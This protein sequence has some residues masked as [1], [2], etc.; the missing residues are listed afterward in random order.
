MK[1]IILTLLLLFSLVLA[2]SQEDS[3]LKGNLT[4]TKIIKE[5]N[6]KQ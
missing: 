1:H 6:P 4:D 2:H 5:I 3:T